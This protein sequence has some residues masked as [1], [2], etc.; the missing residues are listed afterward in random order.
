MTRTLD[1]KRAL[2]Q[3]YAD[4]ARDIQAL[5][6]SKTVQT[7]FAQTRSQH[8]E[9][10]IACKPTDDDGRRGLA[11]SIAALDGL[12]LQMKNTHGRGARAVVELQKLKDDSR[13]GN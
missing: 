5:L 11:L 8:I 6:E 13:N 10:M 7:F 4:E 2:L 9:A 3:F 1:E 12:H